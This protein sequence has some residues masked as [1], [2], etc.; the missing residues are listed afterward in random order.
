MN[1]WFLYSF[2]LLTI[3]GSSC[4]RRML[5]RKAKETE[6][7][8]QI[9]PV[10]TDTLKI[11]ATDT[12]KIARN[13]ETE[14]PKIN[15][16]D[17]DFKYLSA[18]SKFSFKS[19][20][21]KIDDAN[22]NIRIKKDSI[23][24]ISVNVGPLSVARG[25][26]RKDSILFMDQIHSELFTFD[27][28]GLSRQFNFKLSFDLIQ[29][30]LIGNMPIPKKTTE[31]FKKEKDYFLLKQESGKVKIENYIGEKNLRLKKLL[32]IDEPTKTS[33]RLDYEDFTELSNYLFPYTSLIQ[34]DYPSTVDN[35]A[36]QTVFSIKH[37]KIEL[38][39]TPLSMPFT[40]PSRYKRR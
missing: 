14:D 3:V 15:A 11:V 22:V 35:T 34:L 30:I 36:V 32:A 13:I 17:I 40:V 26:I 10:K 2:V 8:A 38:S 24:W 6:K 31:G 9:V 27:F 37:Q 1:K 4:Q 5:K 18:K 19:K 20:D 23:I 25:I 7:I 39:D 12:A 16:I 29:S 21:Q 33:L 28:E